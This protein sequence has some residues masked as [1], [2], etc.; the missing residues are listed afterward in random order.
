MAIVLSTIIEDAPQ[1]DGRRWVCER[2]VD[3][4]G[5]ERLVRYLAAAGFNALAAMAARVADINADLIAQEIAAN[6]DAV[7][8]DGSLA[9]PVLNYSTAAQNFAVL[10]ASYAGMT[11]VQAI[12]TGDFLSS[13]TNGQIQ[14]AFEMTAGQVTTLRANKLTPAATAAAT[15]RAAAGA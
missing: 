6:I 14:T 15:I 7:T 1:I 10:R 13:L 8:A 2:H 3:Q 11:R 5:I 12:M 4:R 9:A